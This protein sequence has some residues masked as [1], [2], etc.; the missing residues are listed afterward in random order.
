MIDFS[1]TQDIDIDTNHYSL[2]IEGIRV[3]EGFEIEALPSLRSLHYL[4]YN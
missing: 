2:F 4:W 3:G 1:P